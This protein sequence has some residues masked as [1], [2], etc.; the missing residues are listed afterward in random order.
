MAIVRSVTM[1]KVIET[2][3]DYEE[4]LKNIEAL[5]DKNP[6][7][8]TSEAEQLK[9][10]VLLV[11]DY[12][13]KNFPAEV[14]NYIDA[15]LFRME[16]QNLTP[17][18]LIPYIGSR[19]KVSE[20]LSGKRTLSP[21]MI[22]ALYNG[23]GIPLKAL[24]QP[25]KPVVT[26]ESIDWDRFPIRE[27][28]KRGW[29]KANLTE[30]QNKAKEI[31]TEFLNPLDQGQLD[32]IF[33]YYR[34]TEHI[35]S[36]RTS[37]ENSLFIW[38]ARVIMRA[39]KE[40]ELIKT[41]SS[42][43]DNDLI[44]ELIHLSIA[45]NGPKKA[46]DFLREKGIPLIIEPHLPYTYLDGAAIMTKKGPCVGLTLRHDRLD[47]F[48]H[49]LIHEL[50]HAS[51]HFHANIKSFYDDLEL[52]ES[53]DPIEKEADE[54]A[55]E[56]LI[57]Q[58]EWEKSAASC[59]TTQQAARDLAKKLNIHPAIVAGR[60]HHYFKKYTILNQLVGHKQVR[61]NFPEIKWN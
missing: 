51:K 61:I 30:I 1:L 50:I 60:M 8:N 39:M 14:P 56:L 27:M 43:V 25:Y 21:A 24:I 4:A 46:Y 47:N 34:K 35:R 53:A 55:A 58:K 18:D 54:L 15:I 26:Q 5:M 41:K 57:P 52:V 42:I 31:I 28:I 20:V 16:Q 40:F 9:L 44:K 59:L 49:T 7:P 17:R 33:A 38:N 22:R 36:A 19:S 23:L 11:K 10:L 37:D 12:E 2:Q 6:Q 3:T 48:W 32:S 29:V 45:E 13:E